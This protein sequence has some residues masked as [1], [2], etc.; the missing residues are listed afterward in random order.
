M[1]A[2][3]FVTADDNQASQSLFDSQYTSRELAY[4]LADEISIYADNAA[5]VTFLAE[6][7]SG[8]ASGWFRGTICRALAAEGVT[9]QVINRRRA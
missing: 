1:N 7:H 3:E 2:A 9:P 8:P 5:R 4:V 6:Y